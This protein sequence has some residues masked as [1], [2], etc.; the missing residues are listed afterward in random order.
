V[1]RCTP[2]SANY[3]ACMKIMMPGGEDYQAAVSCRGDGSLIRPPDDMPYRWLCVLKGVPVI[4]G[5]AD[6]ARVDLDEL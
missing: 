4:T 1:E 2:G 5:P 6:A 3:D